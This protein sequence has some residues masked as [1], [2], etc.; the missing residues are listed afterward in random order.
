MNG[1]GCS[2]T[3]RT[4]CYKVF[5][6][7]AGRFGEP[8]W[9][10]L[11]PAKIFRLAFRDR[12]NL[13]DSREHAL[14]KK[15]AARDADNHLPYDEIWLHDFEFVAQPGEHPDVVC[16]VAHELRSGR[17][18]RLWRDKLGEQP[19]YRTDSGCCSSTSSPT[20]KCA[21]HLALGWPLPKN[22]LDLSPL[23][24]NLVNGRYHLKAKV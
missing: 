3:W 7:P 19:P 21:C 6:A 5:A 22:I 4:R 16:L 23:F 14:F 11:K 1:C 18:L 2:P 20:P 8:Q 10:N 24:R 13:I 15:L 17:T 9:P 12:G